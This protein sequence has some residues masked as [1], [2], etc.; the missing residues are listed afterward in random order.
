M[1]MLRSVL[2]SRRKR[3][4]PRISANGASAG[5]STMMPAGG[6]ASRAS[7]CPCAS[8][9]ALSVPETIS[10]ARR[11]KGG[12]PA[13]S[14]ARS[15]PHRTARHRLRAG[16]RSPGARLVGLDQG[17]ARLLS[18]PCAACHLLEQWNVRSAARGSP[19]VRPISASSTP[20]SVRPGKLCPLATSC[21]PTTR[22]HSPPPRHRV[23]AAAVRPRRESR[24]TAR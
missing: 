5:P 16:R 20:T 18:A 12:R 14:R 21:V 13:A 3:C 4:R 11:P 9:A 22:S 23:P 6:S 15:P 7:A 19:D 1:S 2:T 24:S 10:A 8:A 17:P